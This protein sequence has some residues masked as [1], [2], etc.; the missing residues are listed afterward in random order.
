MSC[1]LYRPACRSGL[2]SGAFRRVHRMSAG[3]RGTNETLKT[4][5]HARPS[6][7]DGCELVPDALGRMCDP[8]VPSCD[9]EYPTCHASEDSA[10]Y[11]TNECATSEECTGGFVCDTS[12]E[13]GYCQRPPTG[14]G[15]SCA[16]SADCAS[17]E[18][19]YCET[20]QSHVC[21]VEG[22][23]KSPNTCFQGQDCCDLTV[24]GLPTLCV[25]AGTCPFP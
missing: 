23:T 20:L 5:S 2:R 24:V 4:S 12:T 3:V 9:S 14:V 10:G 17:F 18:A 25:P 19:T 15:R 21:L 13:P 1:R 22:C 8:A 6:E 16:S 7:G 11:C